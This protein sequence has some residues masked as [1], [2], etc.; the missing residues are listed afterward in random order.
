MADTCTG[1]TRTAY[2]VI[3]FLLA[4][5]IGVVPATA[6]RKALPVPTVTIYPGD[7]IVSRL[8]VEKS[9]SDRAVRRLAVFDSVAPLI[10]K[11][12]RRTLLPG[13]P[14]PLNAVR[15]R[16]LVTRGAATLVV[17]RSG[18]LEITT[19]AVPLR[20]GSAG[21]AVQLRNKDSGVIFSGTVL[22][23]GTIRVGQP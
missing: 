5:S 4:T 23:D 13:Q 21:D 18:G 20:S 17:F 2:V 7:D 9:F 3:V 12:A 22:A 1:W 6:G 19:Y 8:I 11:I 10:G 16:D 15:E 14:I